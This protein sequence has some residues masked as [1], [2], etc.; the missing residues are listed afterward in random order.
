MLQVYFFGALKKR[1][2]PGIS[3]TENVPLKIEFIPDETISE[4]LTR[5]NITQD[6]I[7]ECFV[8]HTVVETFDEILD[9]ESRVA[10]FSK[11]MYL[12][13]GGM[14][15]RGHAYIQ[16]KPPIKIDFY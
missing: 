3:V 9:D 1:F 10:I 14:F 11:G 12:I 6:E 2:F 7:G 13:D 4:L 5:L 8:N 15:I 16:R